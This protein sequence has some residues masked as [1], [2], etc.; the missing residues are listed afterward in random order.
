MVNLNSVS[1][2]LQVPVAPVLPVA[3]A[4]AVEVVAPG[5]H[6]VVLALPVHRECQACQ[7]VPVKQLFSLI[8]DNLCHDAHLVLP[9]AVVPFLSM[10]CLDLRM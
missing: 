8:R 1:V 5:R 7:V 2:A 4:D 10:H 6:R 3:S 9:M